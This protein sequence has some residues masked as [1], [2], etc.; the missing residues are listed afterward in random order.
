M[1]LIIIAIIAQNVKYDITVLLKLLCALANI[2]HDMC[3]EMIVFEYRPQYYQ[4]LVF[5]Y[6][7]IEVFPVHKKDIFTRLF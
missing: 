4:M 5:T 6:R 3:N 7:P 2:N 1:F